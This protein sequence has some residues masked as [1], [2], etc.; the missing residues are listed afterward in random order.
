[1]PKVENADRLKRRLAAMRDAPRR[2]I[3]EAIWGGAGELAEAI[4]ANAHGE[5]LKASVGRA[6]GNAPTDAGL[7][8]GEQS[9]ARSIKGDR[10]LAA[11]VYAGSREAFWA[12]WEEFGT[13]PHPNKGLFEGTDH[14]GT[15]ARP[16]FFPTFRLRRKALLSRI[17]RAMR[18][19][20]KEALGKP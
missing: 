9:E 6:W 19:G 8:T 14:P 3:S 2:R 16:F 5:R 1:M 20:I 18:L 17:S 15:A 10:G 12:R 13:R 4:R 7:A 11:T